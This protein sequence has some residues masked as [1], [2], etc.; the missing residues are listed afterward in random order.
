MRRTII[1]LAL[2]ASA[3]AASPLDSF[4]L[5]LQASVALNADILPIVNASASDCAARCLGVPECVSFNVCGSECGVS[6]FSIAYTFSSAA[7]CQLYTRL[8]PRNDSHIVQAVPWAAAA[9]P[10]GTVSLAN[11]SGLLGAAFAA[12]HDTY[13]SVRS[14]D[15]MLFFFYNRSGIAPPAGAQC[16]GWD[17]WIKGS[18]TGNFLMGAGSYLQWASD[19]ALAARVQR[20][21][22]GI[23][24]LQDPDSGWLW[25]FKETDI[26]A[27]NLPD[28]C[29]SWVTRG[30]L[31]AHRGGAAG[32]LALARQ[33]VSLFNNHSR[34]AFFL[35]QNGGPDPVQ[36][37]PAGFNNVTVG[38]Y[39][40]DRGHMIYIEY[41]GMIKHSLMALSEVGTQAD[42]DI[43][44]DLYVEQWWIDALLRQDEF[45]AIWHRQFFSHNYEVTAYEAILDLYVL[46]GNSSYLD[47]VMSA[48]NSLRA[49]W[50]LRGGSFALNEGSY[51]PPS[52]YYIGF[53]GINVAA[54]HH[55]LGASSRHIHGDEGEEGELDADGF[56]HAPCMAGPGAEQP[57][58]SPLVALRADAMAPAPGLSGP[59]DGDPP[60]G[61]LCG[62]VFWAGLNSRLHHL[63]PDNETFVAEIERSILNVGLAALSARS[64]SGGQGPNGT[65]IRCVTPS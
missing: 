15:D 14:P 49:R 37:Y 26:D 59:N 52:S 2:A 62:N 23:G 46:T 53:T 51:Y 6:G 30:L 17:E 27:D 40:Q 1:A 36:P 22:D 61:E 21:V 11:A 3:T 33:Q 50:I 39:G 63:S 32:A 20:V 55:R 5:P 38:G 4:L 60:T 10:P 65:G 45:N 7:A 43:L 29:A 64:G 19:P 58:V 13:L 35:P 48:W 41:Q 8:R 24:A 9:P 56:Y 28:Y 42:V 57:H 34:L 31:D 16:F 12:H 18:A 25:A 47:A 44:Q 54:A